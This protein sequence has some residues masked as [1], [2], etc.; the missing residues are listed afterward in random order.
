MARIPKAVPAEE[1]QPPEPEPAPALVIETYR[2]PCPVY[3]TAD[4]VA[5]DEADND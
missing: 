2:P 4:L 3:R 5:D 1:W